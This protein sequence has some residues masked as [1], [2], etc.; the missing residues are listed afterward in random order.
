M[1]GNPNESVQTIQYR[2]YREERLAVRRLKAHTCDAPAAPVGNLTEVN[3]EWSMDF[4]WR[5]GWLPGWIV[6][7]QRPPEL[8][9]RC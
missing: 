5:A 4:V 8:I 6:D 7:L 9:L 1:K 2:I 3:Q